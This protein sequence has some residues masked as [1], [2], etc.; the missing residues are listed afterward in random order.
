MRPK[1]ESKSRDQ[2]SGAF[3]ALKRPKN[4]KVLLAAVVFI[5]AL[6]T[7]AFE[8]PG[9]PGARI[10]L[11]HV[12]GGPLKAT[13]DTLTDGFRR[14]AGLEVSA[15]NMGNYTALS[16]KLMAAAAAGNL[17]EITQSYEAWTS[18]LLEKDAVKPFQ[19]FIGRPGGLDSS[20][21]ADIFPVMLSECSRDGRVVTLPFNKSVP[22]YYYNRSMFAAAGLDPDSFPETWTRFVEVA[23]MMTVD[24]DGDGRPERWGTAFPINSLWLFQCLILQNGADIFD[25]AG[26]ASFDGP[27]GVEA[28]QLM[29]DLVHRHKVGYITTGFEHQNDFLAGRVAMIQ[30]S[31]AS[32]AYLSLQDIPF[33]LGIAPLPGGRRKAVVLSGTNMAMMRLRDEGAMGAAWRFAK[34]LIRTDNTARWSAET[35]YLPVRRSGFNHPLMLAKFRRYPGL[36]KAYRQIDYAWPEPR[37]VAWLTGR[38]IVEEDGLQPALKGLKTPQEALHSAARHLDKQYGRIDGNPWTSMLALLPLI[39]ISAVVIIAT[40]TK[41][42]SSKAL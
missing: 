16:Q 22:V 2:K 21:L 8:A 19:D 42:H 23:R 25:S 12:M 31:S 11:W 15:V 38:A 13:L 7:T 35:S 33:E 1:Q 4:H 24:R 40:K 30:G 3:T 28:L 39:T 5:V 32:L 18:Q 41:K 17:P 9:K 36:E 26:R 29:A 34:F 37:E 14:E 20:D 6:G 10:T 27:E